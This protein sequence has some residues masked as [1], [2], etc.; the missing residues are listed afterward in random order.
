MNWDKVQI[1]VGATTLMVYL[2]CLLELAPANLL[3]LQG[4]NMAPERSN[5]GRAN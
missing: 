1:V 4:T 2:I 3:S 5:Y